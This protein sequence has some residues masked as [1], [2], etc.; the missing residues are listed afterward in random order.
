MPF[1]ESSVKHFSMPDGI[2]KPVRIGLTGGIGS[3]K[4]TVAKI[5]SLLG[6]P[7]F[8][9]DAIAKQLM[10]TDI[11]LREK[12]TRLFGE[13]TYENNLLNT[14]HI[15]EKVFTDAFALEQLNAAVHPVTIAAAEQ[16]FAQQNSPYVIKEAALLFEAGTAAG[17]D[18]VIGVYAPEPLRI[19]RAMRR[20][21]AMREQVVQRIH[22]QIEENIKMKLC[23]VVF[24]NDEQQLL[25]PQVLQFHQQLLKKLQITGSMQPA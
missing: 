25:V 22:R 7:V 18:M 19:V 6:I 13:K 10:N 14:K 15:A 24:M 21:G 5:F 3:G 9:A 4:S 12:L 1:T 20:D 11:L 2:H 23:D 8:N 17:L 16:W